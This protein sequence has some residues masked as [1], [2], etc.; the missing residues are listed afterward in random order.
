MVAEA[1]RMKAGAGVEGETEAGHQL[2]GVVAWRPE[3]LEGTE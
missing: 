1:M 3:D 2:L